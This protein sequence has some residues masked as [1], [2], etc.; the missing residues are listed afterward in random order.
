MQDVKK[1]MD[2]HDEFKLT[3]EKM[4]EFV[5]TGKKKT[6]RKADLSQATLST[7][8]LAIQCFVVNIA[9]GSAGNPNISRVQGLG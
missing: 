5:Q 1:M 8:F 3:C 6:Q 9:F 2:C 7:L 4:E